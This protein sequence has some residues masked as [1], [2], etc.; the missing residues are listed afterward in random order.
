MAKVKP[1]VRMLAACEDMAIEGKQA[2]LLRLLLNIRSSEVPPYPLL[3]KEVCV[4][5]V[6]TEVRG[7]GSFSVRIVKAN[8]NV[9]VS[10]SGIRHH[11]FGN[12]PLAV[13]GLPFRLHDCLFPEAG[14]YSIE[15]WFEQSLVAETPLN[16][17]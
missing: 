14:L 2:S 11:T 1:V 8:S 10:Y 6:L 3:V 7:S 16:L 15:F 12:D 9:E 17:R 4:Y 13:H 5:V